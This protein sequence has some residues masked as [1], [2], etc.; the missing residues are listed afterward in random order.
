[1]KTLT[2]CAMTIATALFTS[3][4]KAETTLCT[5]IWT[6][7]A[8]IATEGVYC[9]KQ[10][11]TS[12]AAHDAAASPLEGAI[13]IQS[14][15]VVIDL[16]GFTLSNEAS[17][18]GA[19]LNG[20]ASIN[21]QNIEIRNGT[22]SGFRNGILHAGWNS[23]RHLIHN[24]NASDNN[25]SGIKVVGPNHIV[26]KNRVTNTG[27]GD[28]NVEAVG[29]AVLYGQNSVVSQNIV[30]GVS[31]TQRAIGIGGIFGVALQVSDNSIFDVKDASEKY[32]L[33]VFSSS[34]VAL[35]QNHI[36]NPSIAGNVGI[37]D[38]GFATNIGCIGN[39]IVNYSTPTDGCD[40]SVGNI[41]Y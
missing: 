17:G 38:Y 15:N 35:A 13:S 33:L 32:G 11:L 23:S 19:N 24:I 20:I 8:V 29:I 26:R 4:T 37:Y 12:T 28:H 2:L 25:E 3:P 1:M 36:I 9:L 16:N 14:N 34:Q 5:E 30:N 41:N 31:E 7:P 18:A 40:T 10:N 27:P 21:L 6:L 22:I 39:T